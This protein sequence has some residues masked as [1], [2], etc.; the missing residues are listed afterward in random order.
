[1]CQYMNW[2]GTMV[3]FIQNRLKYKINR[4][5]LFH[6]RNEA[7]TNQVTR[8]VVK[9]LRFVVVDAIP[10][11]ME[12]GKVLKPALPKK[13]EASGFVLAK[14]QLRQNKTFERQLRAEW[15]VV[16]KNILWL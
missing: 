4:K 11:L 12:C 8:K 9:L 1:M 3:A 7:R 16:D 15:T 14:K 5:H 10:T 13:M 6:Q 2:L